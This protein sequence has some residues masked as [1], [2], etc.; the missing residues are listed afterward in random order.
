M[1]AASFI[2]LAK[3]EWENKTIEH[4]KSR[5]RP[6][7]DIVQDPFRKYGDAIAW[8]EWSNYCVIVK[9]ETLFHGKGQAT[10]LLTFL[11]SLADK[12]Q[13]LITGNPCCYET[14]VPEVDRNGLNQDQLEAWYRKNGF[15]IVNGE[16][17]V[18]TL[19]YPTHPIKIDS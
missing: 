13:F 18:K 7:G 2:R 4:S 9:I 5:I 17:G 10:A 15:L 11:K 19:W 1:R 8:L 12:H 14:K 3:V 16:S 6:G